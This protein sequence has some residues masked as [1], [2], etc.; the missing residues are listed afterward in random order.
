[1][2]E[3]YLEDYVYRLASKVASRIC[4]IFKSK[5]EK[6]PETQAELQNEENSSKEVTS[7]EKPK[8][9]ENKTPPNNITETESKNSSG[10][11]TS[12]LLQENITEKS[13]KEC[14]AIKT[15]HI[16]EDLNNINFHVM[17]FF[18]WM[19]VTLVNVPALLTWARNF[20]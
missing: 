18:L 7:L 9:I 10:S 8:A 1:M 20:K 2:Y 19:I 5:T 6:K 14:N 4:R 11:S 16:D 3:E 12:N 17:M 13:N 15:E